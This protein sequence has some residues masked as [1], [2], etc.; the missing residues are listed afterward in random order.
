MGHNK[1]LRYVNILLPSLRSFLLRPLKSLGKPL[2]TSSI[3]FVQHNWR[4]MMRRIRSV[5]MR[6]LKTPSNDY[7]QCT[8]VAP[9]KHLA[10]YLFARRISSSEA[11]LIGLQ[12]W[13]F[14]GRCHLVQ[15]A[16]IRTQGGEVPPRLVGHVPCK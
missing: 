11:A 14:P 12:L 2:R 15:S 4:H 5:L 3:A 7:Y 1:K 9:L 6:R 10:R 16:A 8:Y 13:A